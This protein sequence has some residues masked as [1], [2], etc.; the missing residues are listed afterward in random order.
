[1]HDHDDGAGIRPQRRG[2]YTI[3]AAGQMHWHGSGVN[4]RPG[5]RRKHAARVAGQVH[6]HGE[7]RRRGVFSRPVGVRR[8]PLHG[9]QHVLRRW[10]LW[11]P[12]GL[13]ARFKG[14]RKRVVV[15]E[16]VGVDL[17]GRVAEVVRQGHGQKGMD[18]LGVH[19]G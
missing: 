3:G 9:L 16:L 8:P 18:G 17:A 10:E 2:R 13:G 6:N 11:G 7:S 19:D 15:E 1:M 5:R 4:T 14:Q 12:P